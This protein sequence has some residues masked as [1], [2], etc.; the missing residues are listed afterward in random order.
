MGA[1]VAEG[2]VS[3]W[4][5]A[6]NGLTPG[7]KTILIVYRAGEYREVPVVLGELPDEDGEEDH[8][9]CDFDNAW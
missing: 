3:A 4:T 5:A 7:C 9:W 1:L 6:E 8:G 2:G